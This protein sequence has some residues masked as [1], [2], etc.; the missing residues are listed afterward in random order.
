MV[1]IFYFINIRYLPPIL[2]G[3]DI[4]YQSFLSQ[5][6]VSPST[7]KKLKEN[8]VDIILEEMIEVD[9]K[10]TKLKKKPLFKNFEKSK[11][12]VWIEIDQRFLV[13]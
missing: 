8:L 12:E 4:D 7:A 1:Q 13:S 9:K 3:L 11:L 2:R 10:R 6:F 5:A